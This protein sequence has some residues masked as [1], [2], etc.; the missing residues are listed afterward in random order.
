V[1]ERPDDSAISSAHKQ[2]VHHGAKQLRQTGK[3]DQRKIQVYGPILE[4]LFG[5]SFTAINS[6]LDI[7]CGHGEFLMAVKRRSAGNMVLVGSEPNQHKQLS[8]RSRGLDVSFFELSSHKVRYDCISLLNVWS[9]LP[10]PSEFVAA[11]KPLMT[12]RS[13]LLIQTGNTAHLSPQHHTKPYYLPDHLS[14]ASEQ[15]VTD[16]L[17]QNGFEVVNVCKG[18]FL[19]LTARVLLKECVKMVVPNRPSGLRYL[20]QWKRYSEVD[21]YMRARLLQ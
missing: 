6:W 17:K 20:L 5:E 1:V 9:H 3:Y 12:E 10:N 19:Q 11:L 14:F 7:G 2:G 16:V 8:A 15:I 13:E 18:H 4:K 21:M